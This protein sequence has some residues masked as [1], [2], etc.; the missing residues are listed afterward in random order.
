MVAACLFAGVFAVTSQRLTRIEG[1][2]LVALFFG[3]A[4]LS[5]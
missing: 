3:Y 2:I 1:M 5:L 4:G